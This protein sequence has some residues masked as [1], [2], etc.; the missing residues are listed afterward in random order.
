MN[1]VTNE[2]KINRN[3]R[4]GFTATA[5]AILLLVAMIWLTQ[6]SISY[7][8]FTVLLFVA[9]FL[10]QLG[11][12]LSRYG[13]RLDLTLNNALGKL[14]K[15]FTIY[16]YQAPAPH[17]LVGPTGL[18]ML[19]PKTT[20]GNITFDAEKNRWKRKGGGIGGLV[21]GLGRPDLELSSQADCAR[22]LFV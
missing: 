1:I 8:L 2:K 4:L 20:R 18:W 17:V 15:D 22:P 7:L 6:E 3:I 14:N 21:E 13:K 19:L 10:A 9:F 16:H 5:A 11:N 12:M